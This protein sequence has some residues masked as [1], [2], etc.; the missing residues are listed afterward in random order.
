MALSIRAR[1]ACGIRG[2]VEMRKDLEDPRGKRRSRVVA[3]NLYGL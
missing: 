3:R 2:V 1:G